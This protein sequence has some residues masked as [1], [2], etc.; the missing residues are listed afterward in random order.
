MCSVHHG[1]DGCFCNNKGAS[2][3]TFGYYFGQLLDFDSGEQVTEV[4]GLF[5]KVRNRKEYIPL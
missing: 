4:K 1:R 3:Q 5:S 2:L